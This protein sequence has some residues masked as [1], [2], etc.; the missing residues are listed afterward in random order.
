LLVALSDF[1]EIDEDTKEKKEDTVNRYAAL[2]RKEKLAGEKTLHE[3]DEITLRQLGMP[4]GHAH[5]ISKAAN[6]DGKKG[7]RL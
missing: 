7:L 3:L 6:N 1:D 2:L 4:L 5:V